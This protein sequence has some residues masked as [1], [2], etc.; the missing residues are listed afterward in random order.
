MDASSLNVIGDQDLRSMLQCDWKTV[1]VSTLCQGEMINFS[2]LDQKF[3][4]GQGVKRPDPHY[5]L[6]QRNEL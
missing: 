1:E 3:R 6:S 5:W 4:I 2:P